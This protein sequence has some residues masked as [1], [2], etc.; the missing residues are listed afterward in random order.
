MAKLESET[1][2]QEFEGIGI[3]NTLPGVLLEAIG[4]KGFTIRGPSW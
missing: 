3:I 1:G 4:R 2:M